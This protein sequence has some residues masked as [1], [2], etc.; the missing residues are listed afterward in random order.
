MKAGIIVLAI[1][2]V[3]VCALWL[4]VNDAADIY[5]LLPTS[6]IQ[7][8]VEQELPKGSSR[9]TVESYFREIDARIDSSSTMAGF[10]TRDNRGVGEGHMRARVGGFHLLLFRIDVTVTA[11]FDEKD[12]VIELEVRKWSESI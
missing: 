2:V 12:R 4:S 6:R 7:R 8:D 3:L 11:G 5:W 9:S 1:F 10:I